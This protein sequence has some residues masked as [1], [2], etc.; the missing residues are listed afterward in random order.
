MENL[1]RAQLQLK[2]EQMKTRLNRKIISQ[3]EFDEFV[4][5]TLREPQ[6]TSQGTNS[7]NLNKNKGA[8]FRKP[9]DGPTSSV[10][11]RMDGVITD[12]LAPETIALLSKLKT[13]QYEVDKQKA[14]LSNSLSSYSKSQNLVHITEAILQKRNEW[15]KI[16]DDIRH[17]MNFGAMPAEAPLLDP[18]YERALPSDKF[19]LNKSIRNLISVISKTKKSLAK[20]NSPGTKNHYESKL[21]HVEMKI[22]A[23]QTK[24]KSL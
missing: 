11:T 22:E 13:E 1:S 12:K 16:G 3:E 21:A 17:V 23:M 8:V 20:A 6:R 14:V 10:A 9:V 24:F 19:E 2:T 5:S 7:A 15:I 4:A 18:E